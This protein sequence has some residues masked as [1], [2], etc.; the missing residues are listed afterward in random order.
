MKIWYNNKWLIVK[1]EDSK[2]TKLKITIGKDARIEQDARIGRDAVIGQGAV[3]ETLVI[4]HPDKYQITVC[5]GNLAIGCELHT[6]KEWK[7]DYKQ[8]A[9]KWNVSNEDIKW[10]KTKV[11]QI[12]TLI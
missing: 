7:T 11:A 9:K 6:L 10:Y 3:I 12:K 4:S 8:I 1:S 5:N 2:V